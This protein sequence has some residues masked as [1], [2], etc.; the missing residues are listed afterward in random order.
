[1]VELILRKNKILRIIAS[2]GA[3]INLTRKI[4]PSS[5]EP[6]RHPLV[7]SQHNKYHNSVKYVQS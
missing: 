5:S 1:M 3:M 2:P 4:L 6:S 7:Q